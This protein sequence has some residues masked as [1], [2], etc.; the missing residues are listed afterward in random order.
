MELATGLQCTTE[1]QS[2]PAPT[3]ALQWS[4]KRL[5]ALVHAAKLMFYL[6]GYSHRTAVIHRPS[7]VVEVY[8]DLALHRAECTLPGA[9]VGAV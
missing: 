7:V 1:L 9:L 4:T 8:R 2:S 3:L 6:P 5:C